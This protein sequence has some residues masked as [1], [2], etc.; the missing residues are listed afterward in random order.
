MKRIAIIACLLAGACNTET[1]RRNLNNWW[2]WVKG[3]QRYQQRLIDTCFERGGIPYTEWETLNAPVNDWDNN[4][5]PYYTMRTYK[6][7]AYPPPSPI[8]AGP[9]EK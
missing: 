5:R 7:C 3:E 1:D 6:S 2:T 4:W 8:I 9:L